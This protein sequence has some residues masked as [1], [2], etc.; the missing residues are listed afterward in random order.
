[1]GKDLADEDSWLL[2]T[3]STQ[4]NPPSQANSRSSRLLTYPSSSLLW[5]QRTRQTTY[6][7]GLF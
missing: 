4:Q 1:M 3:K 6:D 5:W 2:L 7:K